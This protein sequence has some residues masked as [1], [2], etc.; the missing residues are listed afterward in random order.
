MIDRWLNC[1]SIADKK[2][3]GLLSTGCR[4]K[5]LSY[6]VINAVF[7]VEILWESSGVAV[8][9]NWTVEVKLKIVTD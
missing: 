2:G 1:G 4:K 5:S 3:R 6:G 7:V 8:H 9:L